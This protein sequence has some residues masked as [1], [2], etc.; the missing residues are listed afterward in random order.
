MN[1]LLEYREGISVLNPQLNWADK[2]TNGK[3]W[4]YGIDLSF[5]KE[6]GSFTGTIGYGLMW[7]WRKFSQL[8]HGVKFPA[9][10]DNRHQY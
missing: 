9:K 2:L 4:S 5:T 1:N 8:N 7:N 10:F 3:G 6:V